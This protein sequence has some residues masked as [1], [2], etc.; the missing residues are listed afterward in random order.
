[1]VSEPFFDRKTQAPQD[2]SFVSVSWR[3]SEMELI[4]RPSHRCFL[5]WYDEPSVVS[6][7]ICSTK[8]E[9]HIAVKPIPWM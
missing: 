1:M 3:P 2:S 4:G 8:G 5:T 6:P 7:D 9:I